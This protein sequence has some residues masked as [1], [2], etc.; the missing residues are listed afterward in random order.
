MKLMV[1][2]ENKE[3]YW[4]LQRKRPVF[5]DL[6]KE[7]GEFKIYELK[8][9]DVMKEINNVCKSYVAFHRENQKEIWEANYGP[10]RP[11]WQGAMICERG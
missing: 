10:K 5:D 8:T 9:D 3:G 2:R 7:T 4:T 1:E 11:A 6:G